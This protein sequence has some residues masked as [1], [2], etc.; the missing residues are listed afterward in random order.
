M[1]K[2]SSKISLLFVLTFVLLVMAFLYW[3]R[4]SSKVVLNTEISGRVGPPEL[5]PDPGTSSGAID[6]R[7]SQRNIAETI[8]TPGWTKTVRPP[9]RI[10]NTIK[11][12]MM[13]ARG[14]TDRS[15]YELDHII[16]LELG[17]CPDCKENLWLEPYEPY[18]GARQKDKVENYLHRQVC[19]GTLPLEGAQRA[20]VTDW[21][22]IYLQISTS[23][24]Q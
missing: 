15:S 1:T 17:G 12:E 3:R 20:I 14:V 16:P 23:G 9:A 10:T 24:R 6:P 2:R 7:V 21:Y 13:R 11:L 19:N 18:P 8:C 4:S 22:K 5:Y